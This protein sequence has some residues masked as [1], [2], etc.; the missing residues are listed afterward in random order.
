M[1]VLGV[2]VLVQKNQERQLLRVE[3]LSSGECIE[4]IRR[5]R[6]KLCPQGDSWSVAVSSGTG[7]LGLH[8]SVT[9]SM[10]ELS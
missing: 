4:E 10:T 8:G 2:S 7:G 3:W 9:A 6:I 1:R 5:Y